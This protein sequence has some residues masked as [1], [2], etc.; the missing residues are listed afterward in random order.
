MQKIIGMLQSRFL[1]NLV[2]AFGK[3]RATSKGD[4]PSADNVEEIDREEEEL[5][6]EEKEEEIS[7]SPSINQSKRKT[8]QMDIQSRKR[9]KG[10]NIIAQSISE[11]GQ[12]LGVYLKKAQNDCVKLQIV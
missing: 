8:G 10:A 3:D 12:I 1:T 11:L 2:N 6:D 4:A 7:Q 9:N 5:N